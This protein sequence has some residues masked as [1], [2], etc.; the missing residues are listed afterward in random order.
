MG[1]SSASRNGTRLL[2]EGLIGGHD[3]K[4]FPVLHQRYL[5]ADVENFFLYDLFTSERLGG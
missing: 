3:W 5:F 2:D 4:V 1:W